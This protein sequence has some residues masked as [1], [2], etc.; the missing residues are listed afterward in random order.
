MKKKFKAAIVQMKSSVDKELNLVH[1][2]KLINEAA[3]KKARLI[4]FPEFQM[5]YSP[6]EQ[7]SE[8][9]HKIAEKISGNFVSTLS[10]SA[11]QN[12]INIVAT[13]Y[14]I[15]NT[16]DKNHKVFDTG[17]IIN[18]LGKLQSIYRKVHLYDALG[19][20]ESKKLL[21]GS[22]IEKPSK[23]SVGK[24]GLLICYDMRFPEIS[25]ILTV[26]GANILVSPS[27]WVA[28]FM[29]REHW[30]IMVRAR[31]IENGV[32]VL[33]PNQVGNIYCGHSMA[34]DPFGSTIV[35]MENRK[36]IEFIDI[37]SS[38]ID[39]TRRTLPLLMNRRTDVYRNYIDV[40][41]S[42]L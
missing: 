32:Y 1:S 17:V 11:K 19:F 8:S 15:I 22:I 38:K 4:C 42:K 28:G 6:P 23:T 37:D 10:N 13:L 35:D 24:L 12:R 39:T 27:A 3:K 30:E 9:L 14:E 36:G 34:I 25:R 16:N 18:E 2:L 7:K 40:F 26:N 41:G 20:K 31:A 33:A 21:A 5:A 29:K